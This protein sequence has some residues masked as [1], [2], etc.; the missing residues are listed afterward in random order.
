MS[1]PVNGI[2]YSAAELLPH[3]W[4]ALATAGPVRAFNP[5]LIAHGEG[6]LFAY[7]VVGADG[8]RRIAA[9]SLD[10]E[11]RVIAGSATPLS[12]DFRFRSGTHY[13]E[14][15]HRWFADPRL[16]RFGARLF[17][18]WNSGW[19]EPQNAQFLQELDPATLQPIGCAR[20]LLLANGERQKLEKNWTFF[21]DAE[22]A[23]Y[24]V[25]SVTP[26]R[27]VSVDLSGEG[28]IRCREI[29]RQDW[30]LR[31]YP[32]CHGGLRGGTPVHRTAAN[33]EYLGIAH[34]VHTGP[35]GY[36]YAAA[37][38]QMSAH[39]GFRITRRPSAPLPLHN[40][41]GEARLH[42]RLN[43]AVAEVLYPCGLA[44]SGTRWLV[45]HGIN[46]EHCAITSLAETEI[47]ATLVPA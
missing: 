20:E 31:D 23:F 12:D 17:I 39:S 9:C 15:V 3:A 30:S 1:G 45:S 33:G 29:A 36:N 37:A 28:D 8:L 19:H 10:S 22:G 14:V 40:P 27:V 41:F 47:E 43:P 7:R 32:E 42:G 34:S 11:L 35:N 25:Y 6:W 13:P 2:V 46:D 24:G 26:L 16:Y 18:Y 44:R 4:R 38:W 5:G 21:S